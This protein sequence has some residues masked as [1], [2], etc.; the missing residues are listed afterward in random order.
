MQSSI[1]NITDMGA[2][3]VE[4][5]GKTTTVYLTIFM[6][7]AKDASNSFIVNLG[8]PWHCTLLW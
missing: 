2:S 3:F 7:A 1:F 5:R 6:R 4:I 8:M